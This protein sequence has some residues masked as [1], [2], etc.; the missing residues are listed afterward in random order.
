MNQTFIAPASVRPDAIALARRVRRGLLLGG[1]T[2]MALSLGAAPL[3]AQTSASKSATASTPAVASKAAHAALNQAKIQEAAGSVGLAAVQYRDAL[4]QAP[5]D[6]SVARELAR[7]YTRQN[8]FDEATTE[9]KR[10]LILKGQDAEA[11]RELTRV[12]RLL[13]TVVET[14]ATGVADVAPLP[15]VA[16]S[17]TQT[18]AVARTV[19]HISLP[20]MGKTAGR[21]KGRVLLAQADNG[22][23]A[24]GPLPD[25]PM[26]DAPLPLP[27]ASTTESASSPAPSPPSAP[28]AD[29]VPR[30]TLAPLPPA[31]R[32]SPIPF[33]LPA[34]QSVSVSKKN[35]A[36]A[37][38]FVNSG[39]QYLTDKRPNRALLEYQRGAELDPTNQYALPGV[40]TSQIILGDFNA[41]AATYRKFLAVAPAASVDKALRGL[42]D[43]LTYG[44]HYREALGVNSFILSRNSS[45]F[46]AAYQNGQVY[47]FL[48]SYAGA[49]A[50]FQ[51]ALSIDSNRA[52]AW[53]A[54]GESLSYRRDP[55]AVD[56][57]S[58]AL[59]LQP[60]NPRS[61][62]ALANY[63]LYSAQF[64]KAIPRYQAVLTSQKG[65][66]AALVSLGDAFSFS[67]QPNAAIAPYTRALQLQPG[68]SK[69]TLGLGRALVYAGQYA[70]GA[71]RLNPIVAANPNNVEALEALAI[72]Q[73]ATQ[74]PNA[75]SSYSRLLTMQNEPQA[76]ARSLAAL[77]DLRLGA[78]DLPGATQFY[79]QAVQLQPND[80]KYNLT[81]AQILSYDKQWQAAGVAAARVLAVDPNNPRAQ[82]IRLQAALQT[83]D[84]DTALQLVGQLENLKPASAEDSLALALALRD[85]GLGTDTIPANPTLLDASRRLLLL[86]SGQVDNAQTALRLADATRDAEDY[87]T[88]IALYQRLIQVQPGNV[89]A[90]Q[91]LVKTLFYSNNIQDAQTQ[92]TALLAV[93]P[94]DT[95]SQVLAAQIQMRVG[96]PESRDNA[97]RIANTILARDPAN[98]AARTLL[99][100]A[101]TSRAR[102]ADAIQQ[103]QAAITANPNNLEAR[104]GLARNL[105]YS[106]D[107][108][109]AIKQYR[110]LI[111]LAPADAIPRLELAQIL[112]DQS[113][114]SE[115]ETLY[116][117]V[118]VLHRS[119]AL[120]P[121]VRR[122]IASNSL[123]RLSPL[124]RLDSPLARVRGNALV[125]PHAT[126][127]RVVDNPALASHSDKRRL[128]AQN[129]ELPASPADPGAGVLPQ[130]STPVPGV[131]TIPSTP[132]GGSSSE[133]VP[134]A[135][136]PDAT[137]PVGETPATPTTPATTDTTPAATDTTPATPDTT[138]PPPI[139]GGTPSIDSPV[140]SATDDQ[141]AALRGLGESRRRQGQFSDA[142]NFFNQALALNPNDYAARVGVAQALRGQGN[143]TEALTQVQSVLSVDTNNLAANVLQAQLLADTGQTAEA[144]TKLDALVTQIGN[145]PADSPTLVESYTQVALALNAVG[146]YPQSLDL[147]GK[148]IT[149]FPTEPSLERLRAQTLGLSGQTDAALSAYDALLTADAHDSEALLGKARVLNY[150]NRLAESE[151]AYRQALQVQTDNPQLQSELADVLGRRGNYTEAAALYQTALQASPNNVAIRVNL[152]RLLRAANQPADAEAAL[153]QALDVEPNNVDALVERGLVRGTSGNYAAGIADLNSALKLAPNNESAQLGLAQVQAYAGQYT[154]AIA[155]YQTFLTAHPDNSRA[156]V[157]LAQTLGYAGRNPEALT[158]LDTVLSTTP[159]DGRALL[160]RAEILSRTNKPDEA[161][162]IYNALLAQDPQNAQAQVGLADAL[163][164][165]RRY[166]D[167]IAAYDKILAAD[168]ANGTARISRARAL[169]YAGRSR[170][171]VAALRA[172][173]TA[174]PK[175][176]NARLALAEAGANSGNATL[177]RDAIGEYRTVLKD[178]PDNLN[179]QLGLA[180]VLSYRGNYAEAQTLL[181]TVLATTPD[182]ADARVALADTQRFAGKP[183]DAKK[184]YQMVTG[185]AGATPSILASAR[186]GLGAVKRQTSPSIGVSGSYYDDTNGVR[187][188]SVGENAILRT[189][190]LTIGVLADQGRFHQ[191][192]LA[193]RNRTNIGIL[194]ARQFGP[195]AAQLIVSRLKYSGVSEK[196]LYNLSLNR[197]FSPRKHFNLSL[198]RRDIFESDLAVGSGIT[199]NIVNLTGTIPLGK[200]LDFDG[201]ATY[202]RYSDSNSRVTLSPS[203]MFRFSPTNPSLR[204]GVGYIYDNTDQTRNAPFVYYT[205]QDFNAAAILADYIVTT[206]KTRYGISG[207]VPLTGSTGTNGI[208]RPADTLFG[209]FERDLGN[210]LDFNIRGGIVR[211]P[212]SDFRSNQ[213]SGGFNLYF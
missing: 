168:P 108:E 92:A 142:A 119:A 5:N 60:G 153:N 70:E 78:N 149:Q 89:K 11:T 96:T 71:K 27:S 58:R 175:N 199:A 162:K 33:S 200:R 165:A 109:G 126:K 17:A 74:S 43:A 30:A 136:V 116:N 7:F 148:A 211:V 194:L 186:T 87:P 106:R 118:L 151:T 150:A 76:R 63:Y 50:A 26:P 48:R 57:L 88:A 185:A 91:G 41:A 197:D 167:A 101:L 55:R 13:P 121:T 170:E 206:G 124:A 129:P 143:Y 54:W 93:A 81:Y 49:D 201:T 6:A 51:R 24:V 158:E 181:Q 130:A 86:A 180:R 122:A 104:M 209:F 37:Y 147:L 202:Y 127:R 133:T 83:G 45:D 42:A 65:N 178:N 188:R 98:S 131:A 164:Y 145:L 156:R 135:P 44:R 75:A 102:F 203:L 113:R 138:T 169:S 22:A 59:Q 117:E 18:R 105:N 176:L 67:G 213:V 99:G 205:P 62:L 192:N 110:D 94:D 12:A 61:T 1:A 207:A 8:R 182:N 47:T 46:A 31:T 16:A 125:V 128:F 184:N 114:Y 20:P 196:T 112:L 4:A 2:G 123:H 154:D 66:V 141:G 210:N 77:G 160:A 10:V 174:D 189:R 29:S 157:E 195:F 140:R 97:A 115:A 190:A 107:I 90:R 161:V 23:G 159:T 173:V 198:S 166:P 208:N 80:A 64:A 172:I 73:A 21:D 163:L 100:Q 3:W 146:N 68:N 120:L 39:A 85:A 53:A 103:F 134:A 14:S 15:P 56:A 40:A 52:D 191:A 9:W 204:V 95:D 35:R 72:A 171:A 25:A 212:D 139:T 79:A 183:F 28:V 111:Q 82:A 144:R 132:L 19:P 84:R 177:Q 187:L 179:A 69:A 137:A 36:D 152:A 32:V 38:P 155:S 193:E 34:R